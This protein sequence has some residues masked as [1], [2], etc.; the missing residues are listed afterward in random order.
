MRRCVII[1]A[2]PFRDPVYLKS[3]LEEEDMVIAADGG[4]QLA[5]LMGVEPSVLIADFDSLPAPCAS[6]SVKVITLPEQKD[7]TD[8][9]FAMKWAY[10]SGFREF[11][12]LGCTGGRL[13]HY[14]ATLATAADYAKKDCDITLMDEQNEIHWLTPGSYAF[15]TIAGE[16]VSL[17]AFGGDV[18]GLFG[19]GLLYPI[20]DLALSPFNPLCVSNAA[21]DDNICV[22]FRSGLLMLCFSRD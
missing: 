15:P 19:E 10:E 2:G 22:S 17:F 3:L 21:V 16:K 9:A 12:L 4:W 6:D 5:M 13:D 8:T 14:Q 7:D 11:L 20:S 1:S 18:E